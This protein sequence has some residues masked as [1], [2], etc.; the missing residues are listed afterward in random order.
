MSIRDFFEGFN[1]RKFVIVL[2]FILAVL[3]MGALLYFVFFRPTPP[4]EEVPIANENINVNAGLPLINAKPPTP[5]GT[6]A[7]VK[8][9][10]TEEERRKLIKEVQQREQQVDAKPVAEGGYT[11]VLP[12]TFNAAVGAKLSPDG[13]LRY[14]DK[15]SG[16]FY[17]VTKD[18]QSRLLNDKVFTDVQKITWSGSAQKAILQYPDDSKILYDF[19][20]NKQVTLPSHWKDFNFAPNSDQVVMKSMGLDTDN[21]W[22]AIANPDGSGA[23]AIEPMGEEDA[24]VFPMWSPNN[25]VVALHTKYI[26]AD[27]QELYFIGQNQENFKSAVVAG[28]GFQGQWT[29]QG[30][31]IL[32]SAYSANSDYKPELWIMGAE[33]DNIGS[34]RTALNLQTWAS[35]CVVS[36]DSEAYC[37]VPKELPEGAGVVPEIAATTPDT[38]YKINLD[39]GVKL[40]MAETVDNLTMDNL[41]VSEDG[42][43]LFFTDHATGR[44]NKIQLK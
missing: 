7:E 40:K 9:L 12:L 28:A 16:Q 25:Q 37:A 24:S 26:N 36:S 33:G 38:L 13:T 5:V 19:T 3:A 22:L 30:N 31:K 21:R 8:R 23:R 42:K 2:G 34:N 41:I 14:Y 35:K 18:G 20:T 17:Q 4:A 10:V 43:Y 1:L 27:N 39:T 32:Y 11:Q 44:L 15:D 6:E 29:P